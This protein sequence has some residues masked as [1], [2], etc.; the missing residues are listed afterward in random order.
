MN[1]KDATGHLARWALLL[2]QYDFD[3]I[4]CPGCQNGN[5]DALL[6]CTDPNANLSTLQE[7]DPN[8]DEI[9]EK[10]QR[11][12]DLS[13]LIDYIQDEILPRNDARA[14]RIL[15]RGDSFYIGQDDLS[16]HLDRNQTRS[17]RDMFS[18]LV[19]PQLMKY[20][21]L[22]SVHN[23]VTGAHFGVHKTFQKLKQRYWW[24]SM[25]KDVEH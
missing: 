11:D 17:T 21:I 19:V 10:Q 3:D 12:P 22:S 4:H 18:Q 5:T 16:Y 8:I 9:R 25:F 23:Y 20:E 15:L 6:R 13:E 7:S 2:Q 14:R 1:V 24:P